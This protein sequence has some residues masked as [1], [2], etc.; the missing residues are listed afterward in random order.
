MKEKRLNCNKKKM[1]RKIELMVFQNMKKKKGMNK[2]LSYLRKK[3]R[4]QM[5]LFTSTKI[6]K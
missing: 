3:K 1:K 6:L 5:K 4:K 2:L